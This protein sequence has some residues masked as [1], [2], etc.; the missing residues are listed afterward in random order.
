MLKEIHAWWAQNLK[1]VSAAKEPAWG[2][3]LLGLKPEVE[4]FSF[5]VSVVECPETFGVSWQLCSKA[6]LRDNWRETTSSPLF[7][8]G[9]NN[10]TGPKPR[11]CRVETISR[12][13]RLTRPL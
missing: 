2:N 10:A 4:P 12:K 7:I 13:S 9:C 8:C 3:N 6:R 5:V 1:D 11:R